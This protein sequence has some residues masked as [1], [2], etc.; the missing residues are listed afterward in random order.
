MVQ[1]ALTLG[2]FVGVL[3]SG[4]FLYWEVGKFAEPQ[5]ATS[6]FDERKEVFAYTAGLFV[7]VLLVFPWLFFLIALAGG[8]LISVI[9]DLALLVGAAEIAQVVLLRSVYFGTGS[10]GPFYAVGFRAGISAI[11]ILGSIASYL[12]GPS[13]AVD[14]LL[15]VI[16]QSVALLVLQVTASLRALPPI[17]SGPGGGPLSGAL[18]AVAGYLVL[19][20]ASITGPE[21]GAGGAAVVALGGTYLYQRLRAT[22]LGQVAPPPRK[23]ADGSAFGRTS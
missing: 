1:A 19:G 2:G 21:I 16:A 15:Q 14:G 22:T 12:G 9:V 13:I 5:V 20:F 11:L 8:F 17:G 7:G 6:L 18:L 10:S 3:L 23:A 4:A